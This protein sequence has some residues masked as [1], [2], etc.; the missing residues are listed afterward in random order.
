MATWAKKRGDSRGAESV[1]RVGRPISETAGRRAALPVRRLLVAWAKRSAGL[2][3]RPL[4][5]GL[6]APYL[7]L[8]RPRRGGGAGVPL[9]PV[10]WAKKHT[11]QAGG[12]ERGLFP[13]VSVCLSHPRLVR[14][15]RRLLR[16]Q[17]SSAE[18]EAE[19]PREPRRR[20]RDPS[21]PREGAR[22]PVR[23]D[24]YR[25]G[26]DPSRKA[27]VYICV[28][29]RVRARGPAN[30]TDLGG[31]RERERQG[32]KKFSEKRRTFRRLRTPPFEGGAH[33]C[34][35]VR[36]RYPTRG[37]PPDRSVPADPSAD[38]D[39]DLERDRE[40]ERVSPT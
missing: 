1:A 5:P 10:T 3:P 2:F 37:P 4:L 16:A 40:R 39:L 7:S 27:S 28:C 23:V 6:L 18:R 25:R 15:R 21:R 32:G 38:P 33:I 34:I 13:R 19:P 20:G 22:A 12:R 26:R 14:R 29:V 24:I 11:R 36:T 35:Y 8:S 17:L 9:L 31:G 30:R